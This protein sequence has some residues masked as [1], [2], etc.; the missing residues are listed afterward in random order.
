VS[1]QDI[2]SVFED[3]ERK[4]GYAQRAIEILKDHM[5]DY[6]RASAQQHMRS[7]MQN[8]FFQ[9]VINNPTSW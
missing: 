2:D 3:G 6:E 8:T 4:R 7:A 1:A 9:S 5:F